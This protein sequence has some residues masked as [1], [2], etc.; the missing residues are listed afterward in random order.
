M[1]NG[2]IDRLLASSGGYPIEPGSEGKN[3][4]NDF[5]YFV[6][7]STYYSNRSILLKFLLILLSLN[8]ILIIDSRL[9]SAFTV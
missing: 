7:S 3:S 4:W 5:T 9:N 8:P 1:S 2:S 6:S